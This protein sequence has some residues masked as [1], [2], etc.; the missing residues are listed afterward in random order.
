MVRGAPPRA[1]IK[2]GGAPGEARSAYVLAFE[3]RS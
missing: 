2:I 1:E 3:R